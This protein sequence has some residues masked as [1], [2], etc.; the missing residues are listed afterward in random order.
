MDTCTCFS[1]GG[2]F[3]NIDGPVHR[4]MKSSPGCWSVY[5]AVLA[6]EYSDT[7]YFDVHRLTG[8]AYA[9]QH[10][11]S[12]DRQS[13]QSVGVHLIRLCLFLEH[14]LTAEKANDAMLAAGRNKQDFVYLKPPASLGVITA[15][16][17]FETR[18]IEEHKAL[19]RAWA[20]DVWQ[21]WS[22]HHDTIKQW[23]LNA[24]VR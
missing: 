16:D 13:V 19:V 18:S 3:P 5:G 12:V 24:S 2:Q 20:G 14:G 17:I 9:A 22:V 23:V 8:D 15:A 11:G 21:A 6:R 10:P 7:A 1:C 4:Y